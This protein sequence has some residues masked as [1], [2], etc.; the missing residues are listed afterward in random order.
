[1][2]QTLLGR[3]ALLSRGAPEISG[4][5]SDVSIEHKGAPPQGR[6]ISRGHRISQ[7]RRCKAQLG[8]RGS[9]TRGATPKSAGMMR[10]VGAVPLGAST[11]AGGPRASALRRPA[12]EETRYSGAACWTLHCGV[13]VAMKLLT[14][15]LMCL[16]REDWLRLRVQEAQT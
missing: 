8:D 14:L 2:S 13:P 4:P 6:Q 10:N 12:P 9:A 5:P 16:I 3:E 15:P 1:M 7:G 11:Q